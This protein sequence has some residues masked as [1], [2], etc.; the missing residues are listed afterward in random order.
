MIYNR[1]FAAILDFA[2]RCLDVAEHNR[3]KLNVRI[4][5]L[6]EDC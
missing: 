2:I 4:V 3:T 6:V 5:S 1:W